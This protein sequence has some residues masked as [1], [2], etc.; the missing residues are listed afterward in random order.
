MIP[1]ALENSL[2][3]ADKPQVSV[4]KP[5]SASSNRLASTFSRL[6][7]EGR[8]GLIPFMTAGDPDIETAAALLAAL[9]EAGADI[10][11]LGMPFSDPMADGPAIQLSHQR[12]LKSGT[13]LRRILQMV[14]E[15]RTKNQ[16]VPVVLMGYYNPVLQYGL[17][18]GLPA[19][20]KDAADAGVD[21]L[22]IVDLPPEEDAPLRDALQKAG[23]SIDLIKLITPTSDLQ[24][25]QTIQQHALGFLYYVAIAGVTGAASADLGALAARL[26]LLRSQ[27]SLPLAVGFG[28]KNASDVR[29]LAAHADAVVVGSALIQIL[30]QHLNAQGQALPSL[31]PAVIGFVRGLSSALKEKASAVAATPTST[32]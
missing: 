21:G 25:L 22:L 26:D 5:Q 23:A 15:F 29:A 19:F 14:R 20:A 4:A 16:K 8:A 18:D 30:A 6:A 28:I 32:L 10:I 9:P 17:P 2:A 11:E 3:S 13:S 7:Q 12:A 27:I 24:R 1:Q 31:L